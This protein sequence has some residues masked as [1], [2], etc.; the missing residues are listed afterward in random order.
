[1]SASLL[2]TRPYEFPEPD[3]LNGD[4]ARVIKHGRNRPCHNFS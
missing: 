1:M 2:I 3:Q 4:N